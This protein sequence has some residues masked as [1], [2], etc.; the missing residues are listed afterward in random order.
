MALDKV[1][2]H[3]RESSDA[4]VE[5]ISGT[6]LDPYFERLGGRKEDFVVQILRITHVVF[7][8]KP[9]FYPF[10]STY[11]SARRTA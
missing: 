2:H 3:L 10:N 6:A 8:D 7:P 1:Y 5:W 11:L 4:V 9:L